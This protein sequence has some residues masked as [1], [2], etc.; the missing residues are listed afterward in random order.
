MY[1]DVAVLDIS[2]MHPTSIVQMEI[3]GKY[4]KNFEDLL[5]ARVAIKHSDYASARKMLGGVL[6][7]YLKDEKDAK[8]L[9]YALKIALNIVYGLTA[10][11]FDNP[12][13]DS[14]NKD[15]IVAKRG[16]LFMVDL[17]KM[18]Q[19]EGYTVAR[20]WEL[21]LIFRMSISC[22][23]VFLSS[24]L[25]GSYCKYRTSFLAFFTFLFG[26]ARRSS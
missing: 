12:F 15:N 3:F 5:K 19:E 23:I 9:S 8:D 7:P 24:V 21:F 13:R 18:V 1:S 25:T 14:R 17:K 16:A 20:S 11:K 4:T 2:S 22:R 10:A 26:K 6:T